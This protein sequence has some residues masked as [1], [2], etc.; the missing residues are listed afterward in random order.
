[1]IA[2]KLATGSH[3]TWDWGLR[4]HGGE[5]RR[6]NALLFESLNAIFGIEPCAAPQSTRRKH[7]LP[8]ALFLARVSRDL[9]TNFYRACAFWR[10]GQSLTYLAARDLCGLWTHAGSAP[11][12]PCQDGVI[13]CLQL[14][15]ADLRMTL[16]T[17]MGPRAWKTSTL[18][19][20]AWALFPRLWREAHALL[21]PFLGRLRGLH[22]LFIC[23]ALHSFRLHCSV[24][25]RW[26][27]DA[28][29][30]KIPM[31]NAQRCCARKCSSSAAARS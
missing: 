19:A 11:C 18:C 28:F 24:P 9:P 10:S 6:N 31:V 30:A 16:E 7:G 1:M 3:G 12:S 20:A 27:L 2:T 5:R 13:F 23:N 29:Q 21:P 4:S 8:R 17:S 14:A 15:D 26:S 25:A 22:H